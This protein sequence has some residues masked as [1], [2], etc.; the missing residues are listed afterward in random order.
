M[1]QRG[2]PWASVEGPE[3]HPLGQETSLS[4][5]R[6]TAR[7][8]S[9]SFLKI[10]LL[11]CPATPEPALRPPFHTSLLWLLALPLCSVL[12]SCTQPSSLFPC[13]GILLPLQ[14]LPELH[15]FLPIPEPSSSSFLP[16][17]CFS[18]PHSLLASFLF[19]PLPS[20]TSASPALLT[21][22]VTSGCS[23]RGL[24]PLGP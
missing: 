19:S 10:Q 17:L 23:P 1:E 12:L 16:S 24:V 14:P 11:A 22:G 9:S 13:P 18:L 3:P 7:C 8:L 21:A 20:L 15:L 6:L 2:H 4:G 5:L